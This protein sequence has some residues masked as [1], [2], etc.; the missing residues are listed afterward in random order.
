MLLKRIIGI[1]SL[2]A[3]LNVSSSRLSVILGLLFLFFFFWCTVW[4]SSVI[5]LMYS[6][7]SL[8]KSISKRRVA[9]HRHIWEWNKGSDF[10]REALSNAAF[11]NRLRRTLHVP[12][13]PPLR[14][15]SPVPSHPVATD[16]SSPGDLVVATQLDNVSLN[17]SFAEERLI[18]KRW[19]GFFFFSTFPQKEM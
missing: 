10:I 2:T 17:R 11:T 1:T 3:V 8:P 5:Q 6:W 4:E 14:T 7:I 15:A 16:L 9:F 19:C 18:S 12:P 13:K